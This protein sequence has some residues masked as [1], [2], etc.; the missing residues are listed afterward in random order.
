MFH[1]GGTIMHE[2][3]LANWSTRP[4]TMNRKIVNGLIIVFMLPLVYW[5]VYATGG[6]KYVYSHSMYIP[7]LL[8]GIFF[9]LKGGVLI[10][11]IAGIILGPLMPLETISNESQPIINWVFRLFIFTATGAMAGYGT[12]RLKTSNRK[13]RRIML[14]NTETNI[15]NTN[16]I[17]ALCNELPKGPKTIATVLISNHQDVIDALGTEAYNRILH[18]LYLEIKNSRPIVHAVVQSD[19]HKLWVVKE[20]LHLEEDAETI[21]NLINHKRFIKDSPIYLDVSIGVNL[22][23]DANAC[24]TLETYRISDSL[25]RE[26]QKKNLLYAI[27]DEDLDRKK[28]DYDLISRF[29]ESFFNEELSLAFQ[30]QVDIESG[31]PFAVEALLRWDHPKL[32]PVSPDEFIPLVEGTKLIHP[33]TKWVLENAFKTLNKFIENGFDIDI[34]IN[35]SAKNLYNPEFYERTAALMDSHNVNPEKVVLEITESALMVDPA[36]CKVILDKFV[37]KG[38]RI[39]IDDF[40]AGYSSLAYLSRFPITIIKIDRYFISKLTEED[41]MV[42][43]V[44]ST[45]DL[46]RDLGYEVIA[47]GVETQEEAN[48]IK[49]LNG[50]YA[51]GFHY[52]KPVPFKT[53]VD[54]MKKG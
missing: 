29:S 20:H 18:T 50:K 53:L 45:I 41:S 9:G 51:Q 40:G 35:I 25:A 54:A 14:Y 47:E 31:T 44:K 22:I 42:R 19:T 39:A 26:A 5:L 49:D 11:I 2:E 16:A 3:K 4:V 34:A 52:S 23:H 8:A 13:A 37:T 33:L 28:S 43:I 24:D 12:D 38:L 48:I 36:K 1:F 7:I 6:I 15:P 10:G 21:S 46:A 32:G 27:K 30:T 17:K